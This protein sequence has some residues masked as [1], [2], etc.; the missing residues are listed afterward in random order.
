MSIAWTPELDSGIDVLANR[1]ERLP[2]LP[3]G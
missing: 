3:S 1:P 2:H